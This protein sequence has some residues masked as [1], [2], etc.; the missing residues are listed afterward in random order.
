LVLVLVALLPG[1]PL[2]VRVFSLCLRS[3]GF[4]EVEIVVLPVWFCQACDEREFGDT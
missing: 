4:K 1:V 2:L 3:E